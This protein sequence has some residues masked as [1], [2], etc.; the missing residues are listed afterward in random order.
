MEATTAEQEEGVANKPDQ[1]A[2]DRENDRRIG[3]PDP[4]KRAA[5]AA[6]VYNLRLS[7]FKWESSNAIME[8]L[9]ALSKHGIRLEDLNAGYAVGSEWPGGLT[10]KELYIFRRRRHRYSHSPPTH[11]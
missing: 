11:Q 5:E 1:A 3:W 8:A 4:L 7:G 6:P 2:L 9:N 10:P